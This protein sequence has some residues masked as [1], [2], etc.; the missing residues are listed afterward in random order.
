M[1]ISVYY[2]SITGNT[3][4]LADHVTERLR[5]A[6][7][8]VELTDSSTRIRENDNGEKKPDVTILAFWCRRSGLD[9]ISARILSHWKGRKIVGI[10]TIGGNVEGAYGE[11][12]R[13]NVRE[14]IEKDNICLG[15]SICQGAVDLK[16]IEK[17]RKLPVESRHYVSSEKYQRILKTQGHPDRADLDCVAESVLKLLS[18][19]LHTC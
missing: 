12:V 18:R 1:N 16:R 10:G 17:R 19:A 7:H 11:R 4:K 8:E 9:D 13:E 2:T 3:R 15:I 5:R 6:G 14:T